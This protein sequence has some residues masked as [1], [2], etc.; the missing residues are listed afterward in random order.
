MTPHLR[1]HAP[2]QVAMQSSRWQVQDVRNAVQFLR[3]VPLGAFARVCEK[4]VIFLSQNNLRRLMLSMPTFALTRTSKRNAA[5]EAS[6]LLALLRNI[7]SDDFR[8]LIDEHLVI[9]QARDLH[10]CNYYHCI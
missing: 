7:R 10:R 5:R 4:G 2:T 8:H 6:M 1:E 3:K 9:R